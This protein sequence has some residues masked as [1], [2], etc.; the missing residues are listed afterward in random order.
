ME[1]KAGQRAEVTVANSELSSCTEDALVRVAN[2]MDRWR[3]LFYDY[4]ST[5]STL[6]PP[7]G[8][9]RGHSGWKTSSE[10]AFA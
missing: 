5:V 9:A 2:E 4:A 10:R 6:A 7:R 3:V 8:D 1:V